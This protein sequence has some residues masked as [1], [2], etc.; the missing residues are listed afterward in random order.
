MVEHVFRSENDSHSLTRGIEDMCALMPDDWYGTL[1]EE[2]VR[3]RDCKW[4]TPKG[5]HK[6]ENGKVNADYCKYIRGYMLQIT[7]DGFCAW[8][9][10]K[11]A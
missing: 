10:R 4:F 9:E 7:P 11:E 1:H 8:G 6:F 3:C 5:A 2:I